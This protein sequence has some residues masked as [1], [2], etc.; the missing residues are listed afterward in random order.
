MVK[1]SR[2]F[3]RLDVVVPLLVMALSPLVSS[4]P[5]SETSDS[6][7]ASAVT[8]GAPTSVPGIAPQ[9]ES[10]F[11]PTSAVTYA[12]SICVVLLAIVLILATVFTMRYRKRRYA[13]RIKDA[14]AL[15]LQGDSE[16]EKSLRALPASA[17]ELVHFRSSMALMR[18]PSTIC[19]RDIDSIRRCNCPDCITSVRGIHFHMISPPLIGSASGI[20]PQ[21]SGS[22]TRVQPGGTALREADARRD[23]NAHR[24]AS[25]HAQSSPP[26]SPHEHEWQLLHKP[27]GSSA[28]FTGHGG[29]SA[30]P[31]KFNS[32]APLSPSLDRSTPCALSDDAGLTSLQGSPVAAYSSS[33]E[34]A[35][36]AQFKTL[37]VDTGE[38]F[39][40]S[41]PV[42]GAPSPAIASREKDLANADVWLTDADWFYADNSCVRPFDLGV[43]PDEEACAPPRESLAKSPSAAAPIDLTS[44][45][46]YL[47]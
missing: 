19:T 38:A 27:D 16:R 10:P 41:L 31:P 32:V 2:R 20:S 18:P 47:Y 46:E 6:V 25:I 44:L 43:E 4:T 36:L 11:G 1:L 8:T 17:V 42:S 15:S 22:R 13:R 9:S 12:V 35:A 21:S 33:N 28:P 3:Y 23:E 5:V 7:T 37:D 24:E 39:C 30:R 14:Q 34:N 26:L 29:V 40:L 45:P